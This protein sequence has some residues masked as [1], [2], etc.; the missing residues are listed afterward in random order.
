MPLVSSAE[1]V[2]AAQK[3]KYA[4]PAFNAEN[5]EMV[6]A[7]AEAAQLTKSPVIIQTTPTTVAYMGLDEAVAM[8]SA[9]ARR[10]SVP[11]ALHLDHCEAFADVMRAIK[12]GYTSLMIDGSK[13]PLSDNIKLTKRV[14]DAALPMGLSVEAELGVLSGKEDGLEVKEA[15]YTDINEAI[16]FAEETEIT[17][18][19]VAVG[20]AHGFYKGTPHIEFDRLESI[21][22]RV[23]IPLV[24]HGGSGLPNEMVTKAIGLGICKVNFATELRAAATKAVRQVL[25]QENVIDPKAYMGKAREAVMEL[26]VQKIKLCR[27][28]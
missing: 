24:L 4:I 20:T 18:L 3:G 1:M 6:Q 25:R 23:N 16:R 11:I 17:M 10:A 5:L 7:V 28:S 22:R 15:V 13:L 19:A 2:I 27:G 14:T 12:A 21:S 8:V 9:V 26:C